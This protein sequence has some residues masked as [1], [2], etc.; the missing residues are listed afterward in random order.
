MKVSCENNLVKRIG[1]VI[2]LEKLAWGLFQHIDH[3][4]PVR[5]GRLKSSAELIAGTVTLIR[6]NDLKHHSTLVSRHVVSLTYSVPKM[7]SDRAN[8]F[9]PYGAGHWF[10]Y[11]H[12]QDIEK[13]Y[14]VGALDSS[15]GHIIDAAVVQK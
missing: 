13:S 12:A 10:D 9:Y 15:M 14:V 7:V 8:V 1:Q 4:V 2:D 6:G 11:A 5:S 3:Q